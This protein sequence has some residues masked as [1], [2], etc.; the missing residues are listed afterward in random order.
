MSR[1]IGRVALY[2]YRASGGSHRAASVA[3]SVAVSLR[4]IPID[5]AKDPLSYIYRKG[6]LSAILST[7]I[8]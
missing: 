1:C 7:S 8:L 2:F 4:L 3:V 5:H 6:F